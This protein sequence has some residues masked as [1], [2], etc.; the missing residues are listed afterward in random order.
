MFTIPT[1]EFAYTPVMLHLMFDS[2]RV[3]RAEKK[4]TEKNK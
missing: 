3:I 1:H 2:I 4:N